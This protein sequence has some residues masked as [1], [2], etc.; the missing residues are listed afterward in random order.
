MTSRQFP[1]FSS[2]S[3]DKFSVLFS[4]AKWRTA[5]RLRRR[6]T[7][8]RRWLMTTL[9]PRRPDLSRRLRLET[10]QCGKSQSVWVEIKGS[11]LKRIT[12]EVNPPPI[13]GEERDFCCHWLLP[14]IRPQVAIPP[15]S[16]LTLKILWSKTNCYQKPGCIAIPPLILRHLDL[17]HFMTRN[18]ATDPTAGKNMMGSRWE[19]LWKLR[20]W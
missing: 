5:T 6:S 9:L 4:R 15:L 16:L 8:R 2:T 11:R 1:V 17:K 20:L 10:I 3:L 13:S 12:L 7:A 18:R 19:R 14:G